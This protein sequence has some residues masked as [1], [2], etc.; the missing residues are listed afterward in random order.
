[1]SDKYTSQKEQVLQYLENHDF[2][3]GGIAFSELGIYRLSSCI[4]RLRKDGITISTDNS[5]G[6]AEYRLLGEG[7]ING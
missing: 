6:Y 4:N 7:D 1:M 2:I 3:T 5:K